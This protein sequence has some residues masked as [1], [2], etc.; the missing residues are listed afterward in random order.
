MAIHNPPQH[1]GDVCFENAKLVHLSY[2]NKLNVV[3]GVWRCSEGSMIGEFQLAHYKP[4]TTYPASDDCK[5]AFFPKTLE[6][7]LG[8]AT[9]FVKP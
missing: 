5:K 8:A 2:D 7:P 4:G 9:T 3:Y 1:V 6:L